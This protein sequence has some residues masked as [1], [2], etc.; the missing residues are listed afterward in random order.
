MQAKI[1][2]E[3]DVE[4]KL[5]SESVTGEQSAKFLLET[6][7]STGSKENISGISLEQHEIPT[8]INDNVIRTD[9]KIND[10]SF[11]FDMQVLFN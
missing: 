9:E 8:K 11:V 6:A 4:E 3:R 10:G 7:S 5:D 1:K 2:D